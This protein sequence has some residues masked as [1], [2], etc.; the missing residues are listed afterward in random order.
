MMQRDVV[1]EIMESSILLIVALSS[2]SGCL[3][4]GCMRINIYL[5]FDLNCYALEQ[6]SVNV[7]N[8]RCDDRL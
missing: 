3:T 6:T 1:P 8:L 5:S 4:S 2:R 7:Q